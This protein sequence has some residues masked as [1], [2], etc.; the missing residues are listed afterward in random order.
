[1][2]ELESIVKNIKKKDFLPIYF[3]HGEE[4]YF[5]DAA[6]K[7]L[8]N[9][10]LTEDEKAFNQ[11][12]VYGKDTTYE[13]V[14]SL[15]R[16]YPMMG[17]RQMII[18]KE[19]Q[20]LQMTD[21]ANE[22][23]TAYAENP[24]PSTVLVFAH[25]HKKA[26]AKRKS[27]KKIKDGGMLFYSES[28]RDYKIAAFIKQRC[29]AFG[30]KTAPN[31]PNLLAEYL[32]TDL[33]RIDNEL[34]KLQLA[35]KNGETLDG[36]L[37]ERHIGISK[38]FNVF[39]LQRALGTKNMAVALRIVHYMGKNPKTNPLPMILA[40]LYSFFSN[41]IVY[42]SLRG[43]PDSVISSTMGVPPF[44]LKDYAAAARFFPLKYATRV[45][46]LLRDADLKNKGLGA[47]QLPEGEILLELV[48]KILNIDK[49]AVK[50]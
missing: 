39:E 37:V 35:L 16:Q 17:D 12:V 14:L 8:E 43:E 1:M 3:F 21:K 9:E 41:L 20:D 22:A 33:S 6:V 11:T 38:D 2:V 23:L 28:I 32:G 50:L 44:A 29:E 10:V 27:V 47:N 7:V 40:N 24:V 31:I 4:P 30:I 34:S 19:A 36:T 45:I 5:I 42:H 26:D 25:K 48:Y 15:A 46:S 18:V 13:E 49:M